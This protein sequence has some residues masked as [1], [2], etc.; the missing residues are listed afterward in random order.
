MQLP[1]GCPAFRRSYLVKRISQTKMQGHIRSILRF[2]LHEIR[3]T[4][5]GLPGGFI[6]S[7]HEPYGLG[8]SRLGQT[9]H[10]PTGPFHFP[11]CIAYDDVVD[12]GCLS[13]ISVTA[14][15]VTG[16]EGGLDYGR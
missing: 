2:T 13:Y 1:I 8:M 4:R 15:C 6:T 9:S 12:E 14:G 3:F 7:R 11:H 16:S 10:G 5:N